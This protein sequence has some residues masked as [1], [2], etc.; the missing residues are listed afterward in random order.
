MHNFEPENQKKKKK[1][2]IF[3]PLIIVLAPVE[4]IYTL[5]GCS[6]FFLP[7]SLSFTL[8]KLG[9]IIV[10]ILLC[11]PIRGLGDSRTL[12]KLKLKF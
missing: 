11:Q 1:K 5:K 9:E 2:K 10:L 4:L 3:E 8:L 7:G 12:S 6:L